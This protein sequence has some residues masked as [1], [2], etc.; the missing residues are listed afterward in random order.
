M[1]LVQLFIHLLP[2]VIR[3]YTQMPR[4]VFFDNG[5]INNFTFD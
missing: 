4:T 5:S 2:T 1:I 3:T